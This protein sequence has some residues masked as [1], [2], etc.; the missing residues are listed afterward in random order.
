MDFLNGFKTYITAGIGVLYTVLGFLGVVPEV[1]KD[2]LSNGII[3]V[4]VFLTQV[5]QRKAIK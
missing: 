5:F 3:V 2:D 1:G 4:L